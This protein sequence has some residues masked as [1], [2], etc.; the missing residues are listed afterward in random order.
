MPIPLT[1]TFTPLTRAY[2]AEVNANFTTL[3]NRALDKTGD[4][5]TGNLLFTDATYDIG[6]SGATRP[7]D[8]YLSRNLVVGGTATLTA[9]TMAGAAAFAD[10]IL[11]RAE[12]KDYSETLT[13]PTI[14]GGTLTLNC[15][16]SNVFEV[17]V[18]ANIT[19]F[20]ISN[21][22]ATGK[23]GSIEVWFKGNGT[24]YT[25]DWGTV[26]WPGDTAPILTTTNGDYTVV[27][28]HTLNGGTAVFGLP[29]A[30]A[31]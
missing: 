6:A 30:A 14:S 28:F 20:T 10:N 21:W 16:N 29:A 24:G 4:T 3:S 12:I 19:T 31:L 2:S 11:G 7:R 9:L 13:A 27:T 23:K 17:T 18:D 26:R 25:Q 8:A 1:Y 22:A 5:M 15:E